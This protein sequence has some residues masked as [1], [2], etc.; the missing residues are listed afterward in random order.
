MTIEYRSF[1]HMESS[2]LVGFMRILE[3][4][5]GIIQVVDYSIS[6]RCIDV[7]CTE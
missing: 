5:S 6:E 3:L 1:F 2:F 4:K 7:F